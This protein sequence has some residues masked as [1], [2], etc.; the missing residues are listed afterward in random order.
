MKP[1]TVRVGA[2][3][4]GALVALAASSGAVL[5]QESKSAAIVK[6]LTDLLDAQNLDAIAGKRAG[7]QD[8]YVAAL[9]FKGSQLLVVEARYAV[10][11]YI[12]EKL[13]KRDFREVYIDLNSASI[14]ES[15]VLVVDLRCDGLHATREENGPIDTY[16]SAT[17]RLAFD[18][19]WKKQ[20]LT[21]EEYM[22]AYGDADA[23]YARMLNALIAQL[24]K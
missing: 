21:E 9:Y 2:I 16:E 10:A 5:A 12:T 14:P 20:K 15:K 7:E 13:Q 1:I 18:G 4:L 6:T 3:L 23:V 17:A 8:H 22:K 24:K 19:D 11:V